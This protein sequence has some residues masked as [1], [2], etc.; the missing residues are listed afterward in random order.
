MDNCGFNTGGDEGFVNFNDDKLVVFN[1]P[2]LEP[3]TDCF[4]RGFNEFD[5]DGVMVFDG[6][7]FVVDVSA[8]NSDRIE[9]ADD[10]GSELLLFFSLKPVANDAQPLAFLTVDCPLVSEEFVVDVDDIELV[11]LSDV[12]DSDD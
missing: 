3:L 9:L 4:S 1:D 10:D 5:D 8:V 12:V 2:E 7:L 11:G 6:L